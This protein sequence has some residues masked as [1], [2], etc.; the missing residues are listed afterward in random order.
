[1]KDPDPDPE[2]ESEFGAEAP[3]KSQLKREAEELRSFGRELVR[4]PVSVLEGLS[5]PDELF[6]A[7]KQAKAIRQ[8]R[9]IKRQI[10]YIGKLMRQC[11]IE[12]VQKAYHDYKRKVS[13]HTAEFHAMERWR[14]RFLENDKTVFADFLE[15]NPE[16]DRQYLR[17]LQR[18][19]VK[20]QEQGKPPVNS[21]LLF[22]YIRE[23]IEGPSE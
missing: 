5:L 4:L 12:Q 15:E 17:Q 23:V 13:Q 9:A 22:K 8:N 7:I 18:N 19:A 20:E 21:R 2:S 11:D 3:S 1:M 6:A 14:D 16:V 10:Q